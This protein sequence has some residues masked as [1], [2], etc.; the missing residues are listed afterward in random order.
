MKKPQNKALAAAMAASGVTQRD[1]ATAAG[2]TTVTI[3]RLA[4]GKCRPQMEVA[5]AIGARLGIK[6][7]DIFPETYDGKQ[8]TR[9]TRRTRPTATASQQQAATVAKGARY[10]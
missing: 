6:P 4:T 2:V 7:G 10:V 1:L 5:A 8:G 3:W 9:Q